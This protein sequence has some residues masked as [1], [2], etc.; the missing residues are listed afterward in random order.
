MWHVSASTDQVLAREH[1][2]RHVVRIGHLAVAHRHLL[3]DHLLHAAEQLL[4][5]DLLVR[6]AHQR[7][8]RV[9]VVEHVSAALVEHLG[10][11]EALDQ[12]EDVGIGAALDLAEQPCIVRGEKGEP[13]HAATA[14]RAGTCGEVEVAVPQQVAID[15]PFGLSSTG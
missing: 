6:E 1:R 12:A 14:R 11:D 8:E 4:V 13:I 5:L 10:A 2:A 9:L 15:L 3:A 7:F